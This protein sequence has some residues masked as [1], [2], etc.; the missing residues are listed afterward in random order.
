[1]LAALKSAGAAI[2]WGIQFQQP[3]FLAFMAV[4]VSLF[5]CNL[6]G[7]FEI[8]LP[9]RL[10]DAMSG[11]VPAAGREPGLGGSFAAGVFATLLATP[12]SA[13]FL[14]TALG[15]ALSRG[16]GEIMAIFAVL[17]IGLALPYLA[18]AAVPGV[19]RLLPRPGKWMLWLKRVLALA[20]AGTALWLLTVLAGQIGLESVLLAGGLLALGAV[21]FALARRWRRLAM[22]A[23]LVMLA[24]LP[25]AFFAAPGG[26][27]GPVQGG[28]WLPFSA[29]AVA[30]DVAAGKVVLVDVTADWCLTCKVNRKLVL[31]TQPIAGLLASGTITGR[32]AD[33]TNPDD[34]IAAYLASFG[35]YGIP[36]YAVYGPSAPQG[37]ALPELVTAQTIQQAIAKAR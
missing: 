10:A 24:I 15:F 4:V 11:P 37:I 14:G 12:C 18:V 3:L 25:L 8:L 35:R 17:G 34:S 36:F 16:W 23:L 6:A 29:E 13:P 33:W 31:D 1:V 20:L 2:G 22:P 21:L 27:G 7:L 9:R 28:P 26:K 32:L 30:G 5:A 19:A